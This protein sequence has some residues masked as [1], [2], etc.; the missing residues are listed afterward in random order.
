[1][2]MTQNA[3]NVL[4]KIEINNCTIIQL[5]EITNTIIVKRYNYTIKSP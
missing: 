2:D 3:E 1:M 5:Y 4:I